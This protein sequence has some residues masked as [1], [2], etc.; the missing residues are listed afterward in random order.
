MPFFLKCMALITTSWGDKC[1]VIPEHVSDQVLLYSL[2]T[3]LLHFQLCAYV[4]H[5]IVHF[6]D[7]SFLD[8]TLYTAAL[9]AFNISIIFE[10]SETAAA[11]SFGP[12]GTKLVK[13]DPL[14]HPLS[15]KYF[16][17]FSVRSKRLEQCNSDSKGEG[18]GGLR[19]SSY[20][21][22]LI[23]SAHGY[24]LCCAFPPLA[25]QDYSIFRGSSQ[26]PRSI[27]QFSSLSSAKSDSLPLESSDS[28]LSASISGFSKKNCKTLDQILYL[29]AYKKAND[30]PKKTN[31]RSNR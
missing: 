1:V 20:L 8:I 23:G 28:P 17:S 25:P 6:R 7:A 14:T 13:T 10:T 19:E 16:S 30:D 4:D 22:A 18:F 11:L 3:L 9:R 29:E 21:N 31:A 24:F 27:S 15:Q 2:A 12:R 26:I 5:T